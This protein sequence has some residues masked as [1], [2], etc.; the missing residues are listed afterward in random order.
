VKIYNSL[1]K[2][3]RL[4]SVRSTLFQ[5]N[6]FFSMCVTKSVIFEKI[7]SI[8]LNWCL[9]RKIR[10]WHKIYSFYLTGFE[11]PRHFIGLRVP[12][13]GFVWVN[14]KIYFLYKRTAF[15][16]KTVLF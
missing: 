5:Q 12:R 3:A 4:A 1:K 10:S 11:N 6:H 2:V 13:A 8:Y 14:S 9:I 16:Q 7:W 15:R